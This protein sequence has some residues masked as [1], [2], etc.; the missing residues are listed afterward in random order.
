MWDKVG[1]KKCMSCGLWK[2]NNKYHIYYGRY[3][4]RCKYCYGKNIYRNMSSVNISSKNFVS[5]IT[6]KYIEPHKNNMRSML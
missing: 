3:D 2:K 6:K 5:N 1:Y 4:D